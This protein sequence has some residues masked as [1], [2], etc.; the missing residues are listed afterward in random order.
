[1]RELD[2]SSLTDCACDLQ[3]TPAWTYAPGPVTAVDI[4]NGENYTASLETPGWT[5][6]PFAAGAKWEAAAIVEPPSEPPNRTSPTSS[7]PHPH[8]TPPR[9]SLTGDHV[10][11]TSH[12]ILPPIRIGEDYSPVDFWQSAPGEYVFDFGQVSRT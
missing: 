9:L 2:W 8:L 1:M 4:Y 3:S 12:A 6:S 5:E 11:L 7:S 10:K